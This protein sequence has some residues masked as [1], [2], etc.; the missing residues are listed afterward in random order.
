MTLRH[1]VRH[2][3][4]SSVLVIIAACR[5]AVPRDDSAAAGPTATASAASVEL[6]LGD[7]YRQKRCGPGV[8]ACSAEQ[9]GQPCDPNNLN[10]VCSP[11][12]NGGFCCLAVAH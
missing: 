8:R 3:A 6:S 12:S 2:I 5:P 7:G 9:A 11:Q 10:V 1:R 4:L